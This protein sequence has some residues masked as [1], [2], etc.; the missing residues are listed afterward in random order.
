[1]LGASR[2]REQR[3]KTADRRFFSFAVEEKRAKLVIDGTANKTGRT[4]DGWVCAIEAFKPPR[5]QITGGA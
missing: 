5:R 3:K 1:M 2:K 4:K